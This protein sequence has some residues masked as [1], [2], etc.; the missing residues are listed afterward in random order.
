MAQPSSTDYFL[1]RLAK[2]S[3]QFTKIRRLN[4]ASLMTPSRI[5]SS[6][7]NSYARHARP[8]VENVFYNVT[9]IARNLDVMLRDL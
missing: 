1:S 3:E 7:E 2:R 5:R 6:D 8:P 9:F 4:D